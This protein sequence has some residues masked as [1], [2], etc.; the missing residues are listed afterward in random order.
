MFSTRA[1][2]SSPVHTSFTRLPLLVSSTRAISTWPSSWSQMDSAQIRIFTSPDL[3]S[4]I[5]LPQPTPSGT[6]K[7]KEVTPVSW[8]M[9]TSQLERHCTSRY[10]A[11][12]IATTNFVFTMLVRSTYLLQ[13]DI[14]IPLMPTPPQFWVSLFPRQSVVRRLNLLRSVLNLRPST[15]TWNFIWVSIQ[16]SR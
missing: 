4:S 12:T 7:R 9:V 11:S 2:A 13:I 3:L 14:N 10:S 8:R 15:P 6:A 16:N 5:P 1:S